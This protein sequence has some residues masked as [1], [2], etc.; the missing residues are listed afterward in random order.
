MSDDLRDVLASGEPLPLLGGVSR[1]GASHSVLAPFI[2]Q[3]QT[4]YAQEAFRAGR[5]PGKPEMAKALFMNTLVSRT[6]PKNR[7]VVMADGTISAPEGVKVTLI[8]MD[9]ADKRGDCTVQVEY[10]YHCAEDPESCEPK[11]KSIGILEGI[12]DNPHD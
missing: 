10:E 8:G 12:G 6:I 3:M 1:G 7:V 11:I 4:Y 9:P 5:D 2:K